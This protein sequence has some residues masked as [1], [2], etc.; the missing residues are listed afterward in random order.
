M[1]RNS[2]TRLHN[3]LRGANILTETLL[4]KLNLTAS[5]RHRSHRRPL[6]SHR[7]IDGSIAAMFEQLSTGVQSAVQKWFKNAKK[8]SGSMEHLDV[9]IGPVLRRR[10]FPKS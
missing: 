8:Q 2:A 3:G 9:P 7:V 5:L 1:V 6:N 10:P 4:K